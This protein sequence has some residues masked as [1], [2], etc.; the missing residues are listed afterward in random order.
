M[1]LSVMD[2]NEAN[3][4]LG[5][6]NLKQVDVS[7]IC[8]QDKGSVIDS[9]GPSSHNCHST[10]AVYVMYIVLS[11]LGVMSCCSTRIYMRQVY[12]H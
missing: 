11:A 6:E 1:Y 4:V 5:N 12:V 9:Q 8:G 3:E 7:A 2:A 10:T